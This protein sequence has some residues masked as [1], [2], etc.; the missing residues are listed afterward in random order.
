MKRPFSVPV[1]IEVD[2]AAGAA[3][4]KQLDV[5][6]DRARGLAP[7]VWLIGKV[8]SGKT[9]IVGAITQSSDA[10]I[11]TGFKAC[12]RTARIFEFPAQAPI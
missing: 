11:G 2:A 10:E 1:A 3:T 6:I 9:S 12:T 5:V 7:V 4:G 8:Q